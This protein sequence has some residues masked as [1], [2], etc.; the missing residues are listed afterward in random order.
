MQPLHQPVVRHNTLRL[1]RGQS[2]A[3]IGCQLAA[4]ECLWTQ[5][6]RTHSVGTHRMVSEGAQA[7][8]RSERAPVGRFGSCWRA[9]DGASVGVEVLAEMLV[10]TNRN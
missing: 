7:D 2:L 10:E 8:A 6:G 9:Q 3:A 5:L 1:G 4:G